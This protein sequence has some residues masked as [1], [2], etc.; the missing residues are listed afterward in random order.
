MVFREQWLWWLP[1]RLSESVLSL[2]GVSGGTRRGLLSAEFS[3]SIG[4]GPT[5][6]G[7]DSSGSGGHVSAFPK[8][9]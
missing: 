2:K 9:S 5:G 4:D 1:A 8:D 3:R 7:R 6:G